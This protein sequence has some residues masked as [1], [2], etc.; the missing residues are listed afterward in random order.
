MRILSR[1]FERKKDGKEVNKTEQNNEEEKNS[2]GQWAPERIL[3]LNAPIA[4]WWL[5][6]R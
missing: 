6:V 3:S 5:V 4:A 1:Y 2:V